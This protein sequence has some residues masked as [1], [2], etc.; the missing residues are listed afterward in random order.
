MHR[1]LRSIVAR[2]MFMMS[3]AVTGSA[4]L[5]QGVTGSAVTGTVKDDAGKPLEGVS[6][7]LRNTATGET[8]KAVTGPSGQYFLDKAPSGGPYT[9][10]ATLSG[11]Q[12][13]VEEGIQLTLGQ[14]LTLDLALRSFGE[15]IKVVAHFDPLGDHGRTG[16]S[17]TLKSAKI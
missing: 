9:L 8:F 12:S 13:T 3:I 4:A 11:Y 10:T 5:A 17:T 16:P 7:Q 15:E 2:L 6:V 1:Y 14:R